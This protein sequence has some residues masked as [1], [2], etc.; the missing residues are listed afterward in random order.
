MVPLVGDR[1]LNEMLHRRIVE[2]KS[3]KNSSSETAVKP[4]VKSHDGDKFWWSY[5][6]TAS[7]LQLLKTYLEQYPLERFPNWSLTNDPYYVEAPIDKLVD[8]GFH[9]RTHLTALILA[10]NP[11]IEY[12]QR[13]QTGLLTFLARL[14]TKLGLEEFFTLIVVGNLWLFDARLG[15]FLSALLALGFSVSGALKGLFCL[16]R[17]PSPPAIR[18]SEEDKDW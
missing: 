6:T 8:F 4:L 15:R 5:S 7:S 17:P 16:P 1:T 18:L 10:G 12:L 9:L 3:E 11:A 2:P 13:R 14:F